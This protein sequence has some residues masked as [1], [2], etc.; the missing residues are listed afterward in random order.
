MIDAAWRIG[1]AA[2]SSDRRQQWPRQQRQLPI[3]YPV[4]GFRAAPARGDGCSL[5][6]T[7]I[8]VEA[9]YKAIIEQF[10]FMNK[11]TS[12]HMTT[13][14]TTIEQKNEDQNHQ[15]Y[16]E[17]LCTSITNLENKFSSLLDYMNT[18]EK[19]FASNLE[20]KITNALR[21]SLANFANKITHMATLNPQDKNTNIA[22]AEG[23]HNIGA[24]LHFLDQP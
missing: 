4:P 17:H 5:A 3:G 1:A 6:N 20:D 21:P 22:T 15:N 8:A 12:N 18:L 19:T 7:T 11:A 23:M 9:L 24:P 16:I 14:E 13:H 10:P 2:R